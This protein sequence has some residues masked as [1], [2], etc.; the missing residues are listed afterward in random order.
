MCVRLLTSSA[1]P[2]TPCRVYT[3][4]SGAAIAAEPASAD[5]PAAHHL[6]CANPSTMSMQPRWRKPAD[7][8]MF[9]SEL[10]KA[11]IQVERSCRRGSNAAQ[12]VA[13]IEPASSS[14]RACAVDTA[15]TSPCM[16]RCCTVTRSKSSN[17]LA[18]RG[19]TDIHIV[20]SASA[21]GVACSRTSCLDRRTLLC[22]HTCARSRLY[23][24]WRE[25]TPRRNPAEEC[26]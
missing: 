12:K 5:K 21:C 22:K 11:G 15:S 19:S 25:A 14:V 26:P 4:A 9:G 7:G 17:W 20:S 10:D 8:A 24:T 2:R 16:R 23:C 18:A 6:C 13:P 1:L 3:V